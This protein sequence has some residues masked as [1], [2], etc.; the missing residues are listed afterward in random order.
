MTPVPSL[1]APPRILIVD[2]EL[3]VLVGLRETLRGAGYDVT[4]APNPIPALEFVRTQPFSVVISDHQ[5]PEMSG[6][7]FLA[8]VKEIQPNATRILIT[9][10]LSLDTVIEA[11]N[12]GEIYRFIVKPWLREELLVAMKNAVQRYELICRNAELHAATLA[13]NQK[14]SELN[15]SLENQVTRIAHQNGELARLNLAL[16]QNL[17]HSVELCRHLMETFYPTLGSQARR[18]YEICHNLAGALELSADDQ[19]TL[20]ISAWLHDIGL[21][22]VPRQTIRKWQSD[23][24]TLNNS[25]RILIEQHPQLGEGLVRFVHELAGVGKVIRSHHERCDGTGFPDHLAGEEIPWLARLLAV[26]VAFASRSPNPAQALESIKLDSGT[27]FDPDAVRA[28]LRALPKVHISRQERE[29]LLSEI[30][31]GMVLAKGIYTANGLL[32]IPEGRELNEIFIAKLKS[33]NRIDPISQALI[34]YC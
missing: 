18:T 12:R 9:A 5:M 6:L 16:S 8:Q 11:I 10:V 15:F 26:A 29:I 33:H 31:P 25:E 23:P 2:D 14:L 1:N 28:L 4:T 22:G 30:R 24:T 20:E 32:L 7:D 13:M 27:I 3:I 19:K 17:D 21:V 34:V